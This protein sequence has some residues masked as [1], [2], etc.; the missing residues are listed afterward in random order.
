MQSH[1]QFQ[2]HSASS[3]V[4]HRHAHKYEL[5]LPYHSINNIT[6]MR[7]HQS[8]PTIII[9][10]IVSNKGMGKGGGNVSCCGSRFGC[11]VDGWRQR[12]RGSASMYCPHAR[13]MR[14]TL[15]RQIDAHC[16]QCNPKSGKMMYTSV[17][18]MSL[19]VWCSAGALA[20]ARGWGYV[21]ACVRTHTNLGTDDTWSST[22]ARRRLSGVTH[23]TPS[24]LRA[25]HTIT[26]AVE[27]RRSHLMRQHEKSKMSRTRIHTQTL[28]LK[29]LW[30]SHAPS[31]IGGGAI[32][33][34]IL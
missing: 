11:L 2:R 14:K 17:Y 25:S 26:D 13:L 19:I 6:S 5:T 28:S 27:I 32:S 3:V 9:T 34:E 22:F 23:C 1:M 30:H 21:L 7:R 10:T 31:L 29:W 12:E 33:C 4:A 8:L 15:T 18:A 16:I 24:A 20:Y